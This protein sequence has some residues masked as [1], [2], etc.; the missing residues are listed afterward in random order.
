MKKG[1][2]RQARGAKARKT[3]DATPPKAEKAKL[4]PLPREERLVKLRLLKNDFVG[5][6]LLKAGETIKVSAKK[7]D[8]LLNATRGIFV[9]LA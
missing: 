3:G 8:E 1:E 2:K 4:R 6:R 9:E 7:A 5:G